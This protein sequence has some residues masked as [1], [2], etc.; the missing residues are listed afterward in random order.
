MIDTRQQAIEFSKQNYS[1]FV[2]EMKAFLAIPS[3]STD[4]ERKPDILNAANFLIDEL[5]KLSFDK[6]AIYETG[7]HPVVFGEKMCGEPNAKT[8]LIY[9]HYDVQPVDPL[10]LWESD[11]FGSE[12][13][14]DHLYARGGS[15]MK[16]QIWA[17]LKAVESIQSS[18]DLPVNL[19]CIFEGEEEVGSPNL[20]AWIAE[21]VDLLACDVVINP[22]TGMLA[23]DVP[24]IVYGLRGLS[25]F[26][27]KVHGPAHDLHSGLYG[28]V[29]RNPANVICELIAGMHDQD[30]RITLPGFYN[31]VIPLSDEERGQFERIPFGDKE[32]LEQT[33]SSELFGEK[34][35]TSLERLGARPTLDVNGLYSGF[36][37]EGSK[38]VIPAWAMAKIS[39]R[40]VPDQDPVEIRESFK[41]YIN[42][43]IPSGVSW[44][45]KEHSSNRACLVDR[46]S[47]ALLAL[48]KAQETV[49]GMPP[50]FKREGGSVPVVLTMQKLLGV[51]SV[52]TGFSL[53]DDNIHAPNE[54]MHMPTWKRGIEC[55][56]H[57]FYNL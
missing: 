15:D 48:V 33:G 37:G 30:G 21:H 45:F 3:I 23:P 25:Y 40:L 53:P 2:D 31:R 47:P 8:V 6:M 27:I 19:K 9:G 39:T 52:L 5:K 29:V 26:E 54:R 12:I 35:Y 11:P 55:L 1:R 36:I 4:V 57:F 24:T 7:G 34:G 16:G 13:R 20:D 28:G 46:N 43:H 38:T 32:V 49:W 22:D 51:E 44:E 10:D 56:I 41:K 50:V 42:D 18:G 17:T 14:G